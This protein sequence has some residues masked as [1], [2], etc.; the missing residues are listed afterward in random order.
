MKGFFITGTSTAVGKT[1][2]TAA[3]IS[4]LRARGIDACGM[5]PLESG[6]EGGVPADGTLLMNASGG[7][8]PLERIVPYTFNEPLAPMVAA[9]RE[10]RTVSRVD[11]TRSVLEMGEV[12]E[13]I[14]VEAVGGWLVPLGEGGYSVREMAKDIGLPVIVV[15]SPFLGTINHVM[16]TVESVRSA[17]LE[18]AGVVMNY[19]EP[20]AG[21][22]AEETNRSVIEE[23]TGIPLLGEVGYMDNVDLDTIASQ[24]GVQIDI[25]SLMRLL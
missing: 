12:H 10:G 2:V 17:G 3:I 18:L 5:K 20:A 9:R 19:H 14:V 13:A 8:E 7:I 4:S 22:L 16:L 11:V 15:A 24:V 21:S 1:I 23:L 25:E 6:L